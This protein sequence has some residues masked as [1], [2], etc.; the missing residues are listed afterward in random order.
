MHATLQFSL[1]ICTT[2]CCIVWSTSYFNFSQFLCSRSISVNYVNRSKCN[3]PQLS[4]RG[5]PCS[6]STSRALGLSVLLPPPPLQRR[7]DCCI[8]NISITWSISIRWITDHKYLVR[9][10]KRMIHNATAQQDSA[11]R[12]RLHGGSP[13]PYSCK[14]TGQTYH[15]APTPHN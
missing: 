9:N 8:I 15:F 11:H 2:A 7:D 1:N 10:H 12:R 3:V 6:R 4:L 13:L 14:Y 5:V